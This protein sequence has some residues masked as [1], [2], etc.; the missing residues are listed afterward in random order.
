M[1][2]LLQAGADK[3]LLNDNGCTALCVS[4]GRGDVQTARLLLEARASI[5]MKSERGYAALHHASNMKWCAGC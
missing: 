4:S 1:D 5:D 3:D 2:L